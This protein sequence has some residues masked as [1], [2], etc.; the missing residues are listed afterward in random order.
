MKRARLPD[1]RMEL[2]IAGTG[3]QGLLLAGRILADALMAGGRHVAQ[4]QT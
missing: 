4:S 3:G 2:R 1:G